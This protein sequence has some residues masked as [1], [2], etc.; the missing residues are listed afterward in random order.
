MTTSLITGANKG[1]GFETARQLIAAGHRVWIV[2]LTLKNAKA[3]PPHAR[4]GDVRGKYPAPSAAAQLRV[5]GVFH[6]THSLHAWRGRAAGI[7]QQYKRVRCR[8]IG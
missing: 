1:L 7:T 2:P 5:I 6:H 4:G 3:G 8:S